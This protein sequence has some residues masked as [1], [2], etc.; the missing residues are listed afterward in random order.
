MAKTRAGT[1]QRMTAEERKRQL[2]RTAIQLFSKNGFRGTTTR[3]LAEAAGVSEALLYRHFETK[4]Q[5]Y[6]AIVDFKMKER[7]PEAVAAGEKAARRRDDRGVLLAVAND[8]LQQYQ[9]DPAYVRL[10]VYS[11]LE[12]HELSGKFF[13][14]HVRP[15]YEFLGRYFRKRM[16]E[17]AFR[18]AQPVAAARAWLGMVNFL[19]LVRTLFGERILRLPVPRI[20]EQFVAIFLEGIAAK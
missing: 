10:L 12:G 8:I 20:L 16:A 17:G 13:E 7:R 4:H 19:G 18:K 11:A 15:Y 6:D 1:R 5:F 14:R 3:E 2:I 9:T